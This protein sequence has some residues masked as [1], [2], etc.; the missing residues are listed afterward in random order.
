MKALLQTK[1]KL[2]HHPQNQEIH[3][4]H[5]HFLLLFHLPLLLLLLITTTTA[6]PPLTTTTTTCILN[7]PDTSWLL[8]YNCPAEIMKRTPIQLLA[9]KTV[10]QFGAVY[11]RLHDIICPFWCVLIHSLGYLLV[12]NQQILD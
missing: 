6:P 5:K 3:V 11:F 7:S 12:G 4:L 1:H 10:T 9:R 8:T 2:S